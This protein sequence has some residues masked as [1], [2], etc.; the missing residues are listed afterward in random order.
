MPPEKAPRQPTPH[1]RRAVI[2]WIA[3]VREREARRN[4]GDPGP[5]L[6]RRL[7]NAELDYTIRDLTGVDI[8][9]TTRVSGRSGQ[10]SRVRQLGRIAGDVAGPAEEVP[11]GGAAGRRPSGPEAG[12]VRLRARSRRSPKPTATST[13]SR[14]IIDFY[15]RHRVDYADYFL[16]AWRFQH[17]D[18][19]GKPEAP[20]ARLCRRSRAERP[21]PRH[22]LDDPRGALA[23]KPVRWARF[24]RSGG[25]CRPTCRGEDE[26]RRGCERMRD[27]V[28]RL[29]AASSSRAWAR[30]RSRA[31]RPAVSRSCCGGIASSPPQRMRYPGDD[32]RARRARS[33]AGSSPTRSSCPTVPPTSISRAADRDGSLTAGF[34]LMQG[35]FRDDAPLCELVLDEAGRRELDALWREL[36]FVTLAP[37]R[38][39]KD[40]IFFERAEPPRFMRE[41]AFDFARSEDKDC[42]LRSQDRR[43]SRDGLSGQGA[44]DRGERRGPQGH[45]DLLR[46]H[47]RR[48]P[49]GREGPAGR[50]AE[51]SRGA[52]RRSP[53]APIAGRS[54]RRSSDDLLAFYQQAARPGRAEP[55]RRDPRH[56]RQRAPVAPLLLPLRSGRAGRGRAAAVGAMPWP[57]G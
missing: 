53:S 27:L 22:R 25:N 10:R 46:R 45:R 49:P 52:R 39:Y 47:L 32:S 54:R 36:D 13:A 33:S 29:A 34:H 43:S 3:A 8:R 50:R 26:A 38:Q 2:E 24:R 28:I 44:E 14:R 20:L 55:R 35:Y 51:P 31:S 41:S 17:R 11:G 23:A 48:D 9:P 4:A 37:M 19:L 56:G 16:A 15:Q 1:E 12:R 18:A 21:V 6:A 57:A 7:S 30:C 40:F 42:D 5:V